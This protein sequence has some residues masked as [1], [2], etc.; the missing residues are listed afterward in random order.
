MN[1]VNKETIAKLMGDTSVQVFAR[2]L[3]VNRSCVY[4][5]LKH[6]CNTMRYMWIINKLSE[7]QGVQNE[8][9]Q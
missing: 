9:N 4:H 8:S 3:G 6:G 2:M 5:W 7:V 1:K